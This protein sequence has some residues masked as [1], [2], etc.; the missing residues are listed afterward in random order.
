MPKLMPVW[1]GVCVAVLVLVLMSL[2]LVL[3][4]VCVVCGVWCVVCGES[5]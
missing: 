3:M 4:P 5:D 1:W 2:V